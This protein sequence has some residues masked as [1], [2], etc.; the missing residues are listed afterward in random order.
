MR[1]VIASGLRWAKPLLCLRWLEG[2]KLLEQALGVAV[3]AQQGAMLGEDEAIPRGTFDEA[4]E[5]VVIALDIEHAAG[6]LVQPELSPAEH[7]EELFEGANAARE[8]D[9]AR[10]ALRHHRLAL[11]HGRD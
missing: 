5:R 8:R 6:L 7:L 2:A 11:V 9:K 10:G 1:F 4:Q 3:G